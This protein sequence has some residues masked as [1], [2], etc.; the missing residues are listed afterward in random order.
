MLMKEKEVNTFFTCITDGF[1]YKKLEM[2]SKVAQSIKT[3][4]TKPDNLS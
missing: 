4:A 3:F 1:L 2:A